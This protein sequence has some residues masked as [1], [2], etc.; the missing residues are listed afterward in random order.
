MKKQ[1]I[2]MTVLAAVAA[3]LILLWFF[4]IEPFIINAPADFVEMGDYEMAE[5]TDGTVV[6]RRGDETVTLNPGEY[7]AEWKDGSKTLVSDGKIQ[8]ILEGEVIEG[9]RVLLFPHT[10][11]ENMQSIEVYNSYGKYTVCRNSEDS[12]VLNGFEE[13]EIDPTALS[14]V[15]VGGGYAL[16]M[17][18]IVDHAE[19]LS[20]YGLDESQDPAWYKLT[21]RDGNSWKI[22]IGK[23][24]VS[25]A[26]YYVCPE[27]KDS[28]YA[29]SNSLIDPML[30]SKETI[31]SKQ[32]TSTVSSTQIAN[33]SNFAIMR[34]DEKYVSVK[35]IT[36]EE[37]DELGLTMLYQMTTPAGYNLNSTT[38]TEALEN[39]VEFT[40]TE[41]LAVGITNSRLEKYG[42]K[43]A[44]YSV[45]FEINGEENL[46]YISEETAEGTRYVASLTKD[47]IAVFSAEEFDFLELDLIR[48]VDQSIF[49]V[50]INEVGTIKI[51]SDRVNETFT[52]EGEGQE[53][54]VTTS[55]G[56]KPDVSNFRQFYKTLLGS[57]I[58][59]Y[60]ELSEEEIAEF[61]K[62][63]PELTFTYITRAG[64]TTEY[65]FYTISER[66]TICTINGEGGEFHF[67][68]THVNKI[69]SDC[70]K[71]I[72]GETVDS[73]D[74]S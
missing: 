71:I 34:G 50:N 41:I 73:E 31:V 24:L 8:D 38:Y 58:Q 49:M 36:E 21:D 47:L 13:V 16:T 27:G 32:I 26:A 55:G 53:L 7:V 68:Y 35:M 9:S 18:R 40:A 10:E 72:N 1:K 39:F 59:G 37:R 11:R 25:G 2:L 51:E 60:S 66:K 61:E 45:Y 4:V 17:E 3:V 12:F 46:L 29:I 42:L 48:W 44:P 70:I 67:L 74:R 52:L 43:D 22:F 28:V 19:D 64:R 65:K 54:V 33:I 56:I 63:E 6:L 14:S 5:N 20:E 69:S 15:V 30:L 23:K 62:G 57:N